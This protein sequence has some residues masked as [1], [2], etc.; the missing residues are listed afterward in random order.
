MAR[1]YHARL[2]KMA[3]NVEDEP[4]PPPHSGILDRV[5]DSSTCRNGEVG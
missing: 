5:V 2:F 3:G 1:P 4:P